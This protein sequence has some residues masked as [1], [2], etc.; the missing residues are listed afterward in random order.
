MTTFVSISR[1]H[2]PAGICITFD[3]SYPHSSAYTRFLH[4]IA[5]NILYDVPTYADLHGCRG[6]IS[7]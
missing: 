1:P 6:S 4:L 2:P 3:G 5:S 7:L